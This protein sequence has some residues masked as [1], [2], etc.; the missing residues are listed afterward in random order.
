MNDMKHIKSFALLLAFAIVFAAMPVKAEN[1]AKEGEMADAGE[2]PAEEIQGSVSGNTVSLPN[3]EEDEQADLTAAKKDVAETAA[4]EMEGM[5]PYAAGDIASGTDGNIA[6]V[7]DADGKLTVTGSGDF[8]GDDFSNRAPWHSFA[9]QITSAKLDVTGMS[10]ASG[11]FYGCENLTSLDLSGFD[12]ANVTNMGN[13]FSNCHSLTSLDLSGF[14]TANVTDMGAMFDGCRSLTSVDLSGFDTTNVTNMAYMFGN[15]SSLTSVDVSGFDTANVTSMLEMF[16]VCS[17][18]A[19]VDVSGFD[20]TNVT[21]MGLMFF[22]CKSLASVDVSGFDTSNVT[23]MRDMFGMCSSLTSLDL[24]GFDTANVT[25]MAYMFFM[26]SSLTSL[27]LSGFDMTNV[28]DMSSMF[29][30][31]DSLMIIH[32]PRNLKEVIGL[33]SADGTDIWYLPDNT[34]ITELPQNQSDSIIITRYRTPQVIT[35]TQ[36]LNMS[37]VIRVKYVP[38]SYTVETNNWDPDN[39]VTYSIEKGTL[40]RGLQM[41]PATGEIYGMPLEAGTFP[42]TVK[43]TFSNPRYLPSYKDLTLTVLDNTDS[44][45]LNASDPGYEVEQYIGT[46]VSGSYSILTE[47][48]DQLFVSAG[49]YGE[50][51]DFWLNG[52]KLVEGKDYTKEEGS[53]RITIRSQTFKEKADRNGVNTIAAEFRVGGDTGNA[54]KRTAQNF[55]IDERASENNGSNEGNGSDDNKGDDGSGSHNTGSG[56]DSDHTSAAPAAHATAIIRLS[57]SSGSPFAG[58]LLELHSTPMEAATDANGAAVFNNVEEGWHTLYVKTRDGKLLASKGFELLFGDEEKMNGDLIMVKAGS[59]FT[60]N[61]RMD[62]DNL[63]FINVNGDTGAGVQETADVQQKEAYMVRAASTGD[64]D[65]PGIWFV[66][67]VSCG[68]LLT[69]FFWKERKRQIR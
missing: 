30:G 37:D 47:L 8:S 19:S 53:T 3:G 39:I 18:L 42:I 63:S 11:L 23:N 69:A 44:N 64:S 12:T 57:A 55:R 68:L 31:C 62:G 43:A 51:I 40:A 26:C 52:E 36:D 29:D 9:D 7:I 46:L 60:M 6:W 1:F 32:T 54:L 35:E 16:F 58:L 38:Y 65:D 21:D 49:S 10:D 4:N 20:T 45:V 33:P 50:F 41:Y 15:C 14:D 48:T 17:S 66:L 67:F 22:N 27:D 2:N 56:G 25:D 24:S 5:R 61:V 28:T 34:D 13:M 59:V